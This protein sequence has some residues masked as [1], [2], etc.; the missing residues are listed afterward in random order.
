MARVYKAKPNSSDWWID[1]N[2]AHGRRR[3]AKVGPNKAVAHKVLGERLKQV[4]EELELGIKHIEKMSFE[5]FAPE[6]LEVH[7]K[8]NKRSWQRD[9]I[10]IRKHLT[11]FFGDKLLS[12]IGSEDIEKYR[13]ARVKLVSKSTVNREMDCLT[14]LLNKAVEWGKLRENPA[15]KVKDFKVD[16]RRLVYLERGECARLLEACRQDFRPI[17]ETF[18]LTGLRKSELFSL[19][20]ADID[21]RA[22]VIQGLEDQERK[23]SPYP[24]ER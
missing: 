11:P 22:G 24:L 23:A 13:A 10:V 7:A 15:L 12:E 19:R 6:Y 14:T 16:N 1:Y 17:A 18:I 4:T 5:V 21:L 20:W 2:D 8:A 3:R 9:E